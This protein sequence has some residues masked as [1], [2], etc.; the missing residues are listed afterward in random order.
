[1]EP[2]KWYCYQ[3]HCIY[4]YVYV[5]M[6]VYLHIFMATRSHYIPE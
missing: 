4:M 1:L 3:M 5:R 6:Y 2:F